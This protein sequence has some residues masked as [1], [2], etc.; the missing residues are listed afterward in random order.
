MRIGL[1][2]VNS[3]FVH[4]S[5]A[6]YYL[7]ET[8]PQSCDCVMEEYNIN[9]P[10]LQIFYDILAG[11]YDLLAIPV[12]I[13]NKE[14]VR[15]LLPL[16]KQVR[17]PMILVVGGPEPTYAP[18]DFPAA[19]YIVSGALESTWPSLVE[20]LSKGEVA[21]RL[22]G[23]KGIPQFSQDWPF[24]YHEEDLEHLKNRLVYY[25]T[26]RGCPYQCAFCL[27]S[28]ERNTAFLPL[29]RVK[30]ELLFFL[31][32]GIPVVKLVD[33]TFN[34]PQDRAKEI[35][36][37]LIEHYHPGVTFHFELKGELIDNEMLAL[38][39]SAPKDLF[40]VE[41]GVQT[42]NEATLKESHRH[43][44]W[45]R[46]KKVYASLIAAENIHT[47]FD[48]IAGLPHEDFIS[49]Q[50]SFDEVM[51]ME[52][53]YLQLGFLK[54]LPGTRL[55]KEQGKH[56]YVAL[57]FP[58]Y[59]V[60]QGNDISPSELAILK[61]VDGFLD[62]VYNKGVARNLLHYAASVWHGSIF[63]LFCILAE[64]D[65]APANTLC[66][67]MPEEHEILIGMER[68]D[69]F[70]YGGRK[71]QVTSEEERDVRNF[72]REEELIQEYLPHYSGFPTREIY[73]R[74]RIITL[75]FVPDLSGRFVAVADH[76]RAKVLIDYKAKGMG[77]K[78][79]GNASIFLLKP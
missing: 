43:S 45:H 39:I 48:L 46:V 27:S 58:P 25:E 50:R 34:F 31:E 22:P 61:K 32:A 4:S 13:W 53:D 28:A 44:E 15:K 63:S 12:Y 51:S 36:S 33:R 42:L 6:L 7:R 72:L 71:S 69:S 78:G 73:K 54:L 26:S 67:M 20:A 68:L 9:E 57:P 1:I 66:H 37:F 65:D 19:D 59:E 3:Q 11:D 47:H 49:F 14:V 56:G 55:W 74:I 62:S 41:I 29:E 40:Q 79:K 52:P 75:P 10:F 5:L 2:G 60:V 38:L 8:A 70:L 16:L 17:P 18:D 21:P 23:L 64:S 77:K 24:P 35:I 76:G 30:K